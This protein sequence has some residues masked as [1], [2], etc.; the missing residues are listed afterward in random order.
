MGWHINNELCQKYGVELPQRSSFPSPAPNNLK[1]LYSARVIVTDGRGMCPHREHPPKRFE[2]VL[3][4]DK[5]ISKRRRKGATLSLI[6]TS[7]IHHL[8]N[9]AVVTSLYNT[10]LCNALL[11][12]YRGVWYH[13]ETEQDREQGKK[14]EEKLRGSKWHIYWLF[15]DSPP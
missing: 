6:L 13:A 7:S 1:L 8:L 2:G 5:I 12:Q 3:W 15:V 11:H 9:T 14:E 4:P 10:N